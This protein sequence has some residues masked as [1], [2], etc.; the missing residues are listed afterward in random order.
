[1]NRKTIINRLPHTPTTLKLTFNKIEG[2]RNKRQTEPKH[3]QNK[4]QL[5]I[6]AKYPVEEGISSLLPSSSET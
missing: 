4:F 5:S 2:A 1:M 3:K 6:L